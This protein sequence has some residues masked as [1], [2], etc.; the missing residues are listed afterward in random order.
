MYNLGN[1][2]NNQVKEKIIRRLI[3]IHPSL[4]PLK[5]VDCRVVTA[6]FSLTIAMTKLLVRQTDLVWM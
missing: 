2:L 1:G 3:W 6:S 5:D 4:L